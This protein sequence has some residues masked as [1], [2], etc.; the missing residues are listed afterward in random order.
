[1]STY[2]LVA[3]VAESVASQVELS[4]RVIMLGAGTHELAYI[5]L[6]AFETVND[7]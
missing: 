2:W 6:C 1:M 5:V 4:R 7:C 3:S